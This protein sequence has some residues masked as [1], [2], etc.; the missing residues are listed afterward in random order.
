M[1]NHL[2]SNYQ[3]KLI[4]IMTIIKSNNNKFQT[5]NF[6]PQTFNALFNSLLNDSMIKTETNEFIPSADILEK[7]N[8]YEIHLLLPKIKKEDIKISL[9]DVYLKVEGE[10]KS[11]QTAE[12]E[13]YFRREISYGKFSRSFKV[14]KIDVSKIEAELNEGVLNIVV[15]KQNEKIEHNIQIK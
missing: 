2:K 1:A 3:I 9:E 8:H 12:K 6:F 5:E 13:K 10:R 11:E 4:N 15:P 7:E 14:G